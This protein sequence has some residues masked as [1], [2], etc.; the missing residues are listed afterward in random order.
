[1]LVDTNLLVRT[2]QPHHPLFPIADGAISALRYRGQRLYLVPQNLLELWTVATRPIAANSLGL[3]TNVARSEIER[4][5]RF[6]TILPETP[7]I[8]P[9]WKRL[10]FDHEVRG[11]RRMTLN[12]SPPCM[13]MASAQFLPSTN[14]AFH[15]I[16]V[17][18]FSIRLRLIDLA[19]EGGFHVVCV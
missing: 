19:D 5:E 14:P 2:L 11:S 8:Y 4:M 12:S 16:R 9:V 1:M 18:K 15:A 3:L 13:C 17:S 10:V 6:F 7:A